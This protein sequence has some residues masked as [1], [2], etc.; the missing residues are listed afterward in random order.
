LVA[1]LQPELLARRPTVVRRYQRIRA[2][3]RLALA[4]EHHQ[5]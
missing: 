2:A 3:Q 4:R 5:R 1:F